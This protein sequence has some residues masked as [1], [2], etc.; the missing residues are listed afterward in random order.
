MAERGEDGD[1]PLGTTVFPARVRET[2]FTLAAMVAQLHD[3]TK[4]KFVHFSFLN[5]LRM[6]KKYIAKLSFSG[7]RPILRVCTIS[8]LPRDP[9]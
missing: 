9:G 7:Y 3:D 4:T 8:Y 5:G 1:V 6:G 2:C